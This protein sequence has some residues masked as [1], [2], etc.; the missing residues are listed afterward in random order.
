ML[1]V[2]MIPRALS[3]EENQDSEPTIA[4][5][6]RRPRQIAGSAFTPDPLNGNRAPIYVSED[7]G[8][9]WRLNADV[10]SQIETSDITVAFGSRGALYAGILR[11]P[12]PPHDTRLNILRTPDFRAPAA[13]SVLVNRIGP[14]QPFVQTASIKGKDRVY[15]G[16]NDTA[17]VDGRSATIDYS[18]SASSS[19]TFKSVRLEARSTGI[20]AQD[21]PQVRPAIHRDGTVYAVFLAWRQQRGDWERNTLVITG[22]VVLVRDD[23]GGA[24]KNPFA[25][26]TDPTDGAVGR[27]VATNI[28]FPFQQT[29]DGVPGQQRL[30]GDLAIAVDPRTS[31][32]VY[33]AWADQPAGGAYTLHIRRSDDRGATWSSD[34]RVVAGAINAALAVNSAGRLGFLYQALSG[35]PRRWVTHLERASPAGSWDDLVLSSAPANDPP[36]KFDPYLGDYAHLM[37]V[38][39]RFYGVF[40]ASNAPD[41][42]NFPQGV[43]YQRLV[44][45]STHRL[46]REDGGAVRTSID[47]FFFRVAG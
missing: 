46:L 33:I 25:A 36:K 43:R 18:L 5:N 14:D 37:A 30:G 28:T 23:A 21:G 41:M 35:T 8:S 4:V 40:S 34:L 11:Q 38:G 7:G 24:G 20:P 16:D 45:F 19:T 6:P 12:S 15:V 2:N 47:P 9:S 27:L 22:D 13:M 29:G 26:L 10:P 31:A 42:A 44:D 39:R 32:R 17:V 3:Y 1:V